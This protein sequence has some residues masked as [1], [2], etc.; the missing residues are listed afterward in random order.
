MIGISPAATNDQHIASLLLKEDDTLERLEQGRRASP[1]CLYGFRH[2]DTQED[3]SSEEGIRRQKSL[4][5]I[6]ATFQPEV[7]IGRHQLPFM[8]G[9]AI[10]TFDSDGIYMSA[11]P[12]L[13][14]ADSVQSVG[15]SAFHPSTWWLEH[16]TSDVGWQHTH[17]SAMRYFQRHRVLE[18]F[19]V[20]A[21]QEDDIALPPILRGIESPT[22]N[23]NFIHIYESAIRYFRKREISERLDVIAQREDNWDGFES[24]K[25]L[26][27]S[28][29]RAKRLME[30]LLDDILSAGYSWLEPR[31]FIS[32][33]E[34]GYITVEWYGEKRQLHLRVEEDEV[35]YIKLQRI[36]NRRKVHVDTIRSEDCFALWKWLI[37]E[38]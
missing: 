21:Q 35:E 12:N 38:Q 19:D 37:N 1:E 18:G 4:E 6:G 31:P 2:G 14:R 36:N 16:L 32:S 29:Y 25:P 34:D 30:K 33:D 22:A 15:G 24:K 13:P 27:V 20:I 10:V 11:S 9:Q 17:N 28:L 23:A 3:S 8:G 5:L 7:L 26:E